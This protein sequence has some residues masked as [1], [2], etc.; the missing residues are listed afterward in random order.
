MPIRVALSILWKSLFIQAA[1]NFK[2]MQNIGFTHAILPGLKHIIPGKIPDAIKHYIPFFNTQPYMAPT[3]IGVFLHL[4]GQGDEE[5]IEKI[6]PSLTG[7]LAAIGDTF[8]WTTLKPLL[9][10][11][12]LI[13]AITDQLWGLFIAL[14]LFNSVHF[15]TMA[16]GFFL[17]YLQGPH[18][19]LSLG[20]MLSVDFSKNVSLLIPLLSGI[21]FCLVPRWI[22]IEHG[23][24]A[25]IFIFVTSTVLIKLRV[26]IFWLVYGVFTLS[27][28]WTMLL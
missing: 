23:L 6:R 5:M 15:W 28:L 9:A 4:H 25:G 12:L 24:I 3:A 2:G 22:G 13:S 18:G 17:G 21:I 20:R 7:S 14:I 27:M 10:L 11:F 1:W 8:F 26:N 16:W 19:A